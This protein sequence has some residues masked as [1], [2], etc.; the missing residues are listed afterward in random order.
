MRHKEM[1]PETPDIIVT[2]RVPREVDAEL[3]MLAHL[4][5]RTK[6]AVIRV[7]LRE[8]IKRLEGRNGK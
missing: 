7:A 3:T 4:E 2:V 1:K 5:E 8:Y 6:G